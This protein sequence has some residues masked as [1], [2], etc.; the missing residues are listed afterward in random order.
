MPKTIETFGVSESNVKSQS[1]YTFEIRDKKIK[2]DIDRV[3]LWQ[4]I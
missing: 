2:H 3:P 1:F 4:A